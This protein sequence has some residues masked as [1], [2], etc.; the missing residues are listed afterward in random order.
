MAIRECPKCGSR[1]KFLGED[2]RSYCSHCGFKFAD[3]L[4]EVWEQ[5]NEALK[6]I[7]FKERDYHY[8]QGV[9]TINL[10]KDKFAIHLEF[11]EKEDVFGE[12]E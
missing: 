1:L 4:D 9:E 3:T 11:G 10:I 5:I 7:G 12:E 2:G 8:S 6:G